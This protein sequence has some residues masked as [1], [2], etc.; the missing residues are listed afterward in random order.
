MCY[1]FDKNWFFCQFLDVE[2]GQAVEQQWAHCGR[3]LFVQNFVIAR[4]RRSIFGVFFLSKL[5]T[6]PV[7][8]VLLLY[9]SVHS[10]LDWLVNKGKN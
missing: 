4:M 6:S 10:S 3:T 5:G 7:I 8:L 1:N 9:Q 2:L